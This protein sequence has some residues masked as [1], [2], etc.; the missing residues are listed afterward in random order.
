MK[1]YKN[2]FGMI[3][4]AVIAILMGLFMGVAT[5]I[6]NHT[7]ITWVTLFNTWACIFLLVTLVLMLLPVNVWGEKLAA[8]FGCKPRTLAF[9][10]ISNLLPSLIINTILSAVMPAMNI[11]YNEAIPA[12]ARMGA[13][14]GAFLGGWPV[15]FVISYVCALIAGKIGETVAVKTIGSPGGPAD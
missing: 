9:T 5:L 8:K 4:S 1:C 11:F 3:V 14:L 2:H 10:L 15:T 12:P 6:V 13:F 7:P